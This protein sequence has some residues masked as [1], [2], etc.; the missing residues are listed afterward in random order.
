[1]T[2]LDK[3]RLEKDLTGST[4]IVLRSQLLSSTQ[5]FIAPALALEEHYIP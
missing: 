3:E 2:A 1:M 4:W 5:S